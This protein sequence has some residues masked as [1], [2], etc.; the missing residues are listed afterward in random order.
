VKS[1]ICAAVAVLAL[2]ATSPASAAALLN[3]GFEM[4][5]ALNFGTYYRG[6]LAPT[7]WS[8]VAGLEAP[9]IL[10]DAYNQT[11]AGFAQLLDPHG[12]SRFLDMNG[13]SPT[14][15]IFQDITG[16]TPGSAVTLTYWVGRWAQNSAGTLTA[17]LFGQATTA[18]TVTLDYLPGATSSNWVQYSLSGVAPVSGTVRV[19]FVG[20]SGSVARGAPGLD[21]VAFAAVA[22]IGGVPEPAAWGLMILGFGLAGSTLRARRRAT[23]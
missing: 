22:P 5:P 15:G 17:T 11:G 14:G 20:N 1:L 16:L 4:G 8:P 3:G 7:G 9:D 2:G 6:P 12:G 21:D 19:Q 23:A 10:D 18:A 13:A